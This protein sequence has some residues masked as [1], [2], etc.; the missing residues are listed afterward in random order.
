[1]KR[2]ICVTI[3]FTVIWGC[4]LGF[5]NHQE[6]PLFYGL[7]YEYHPVDFKNLQTGPFLPVV[8]IMK[9]RSS[10]P[11]GERR[12]VVEIPPVGVSLSDRHQWIASP[13]M[14]VRDFL[15]KDLFSDGRVQIVERGTAGPEPFYGISGRIEKFSWVQMENGNFRAELQATLQLWSDRLRK[16]ILSR[17]YSYSSPEYHHNSPEVF[18]SSMSKLVIRLSKDF[19]RDL[20]VAL[21]GKGASDF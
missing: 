4:S 1:M 5:L 9:F 8:S 11:F 21:F 7:F 18:A 16:V 12:M 20:Y 6:A 14:L 2:S 17:R 19:R 15:L 10:Y 3:M 13:P